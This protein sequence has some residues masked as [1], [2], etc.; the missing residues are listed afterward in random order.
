MTRDTQ[1]WKDL[2]MSDGRGGRVYLSKTDLHRLE[3]EGAIDIEQD[4]EY[5]VST[6]VSDG[7]ARVFIE[8]REKQPE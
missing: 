3:R 8:L 5:S 2:P 6:G 7:R 1:K 4:I